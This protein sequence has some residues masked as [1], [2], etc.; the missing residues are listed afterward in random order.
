[1][2]TLNRLVTPALVA[3]ALLGGGALN[4]AHAETLG[5][6]DLTGTAPV[7]EAYAGFQWGAGWY[8]LSTANLPTPYVV[9]SNT[10]L[11][12]RRHDGRPFYFDGADF[13]SR[14]GLDANGSFYFVLYLRGQTVYTGAGSSK[15]R[16]RF[17]ATPTLF[18]PP[19]TGL[20]DM[21]A[22]G[23]AGN[24]KDWN[25]LAMDNFRF[26]PAP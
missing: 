11:F 9:A 6:N 19:Y 3:T 14:R 1:M 10:S 21:V 2:K 7:P 4:P 20:V 18:R 8:S 15:A 17:T 24:G 16:M 13:W 25:H 12:M 5:F 26:R 23:F 22:I